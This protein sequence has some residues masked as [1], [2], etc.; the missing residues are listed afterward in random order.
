M[1]ATR[2]DPAPARSDDPA[3]APK[4]EGAFLVTGAAGFLGS[5]M[6]DRLLAEGKRVVGVDNFLTGDRRNLA[7]A[8][9][10]PG[11]RLHEADVTRH[12]EMPEPVAWVLHFASPASP[13]DYA[14]IP[15]DALRSGYFGA[16]NSLGLA[17]HKGAGFLLVSS[18]EVYG[19]PEVSP[20]KEGYRGN[21]DHLAPSGCYDVAKIAAE[22]LA[23]AY[24]RMYSMPVRIAR[25]FGTYGPRM[26]PDDGRAVSTF[27]RHAARG[28]PLGVHGDGGHQRS[29]TFV[30]DVIDGLWRLARSTCGHPVNLGHPDAISVLVL[31]RAV[32]DAFGSRSPIEFLPALPDDP[33]VRR[34]DIALA[35]QAL[36]WRPV[37]SLA[38]GL[39]RTVAW[40]R[41]HPE[42][43]EGRA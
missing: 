3:G 16:Y 22:S 17:R 26:R 27:I 33:K 18:P 40:C 20:Q 15:H 2:R 31:A 32:R 23:M 39:R 13:A 34:P 41:R 1:T 38:E 29:F 24:Q 8:A 28:A 37:T 35:Q 36:D 7:D 10:N 19:D 42:R 30:D 25:V 5:H 11:F 14:A 6:V 12:F 43:L 4:P 21:F 9:R